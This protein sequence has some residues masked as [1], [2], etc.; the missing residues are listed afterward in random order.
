MVQKIEAGAAAGSNSNFSRTQS[1]EIIKN[2]LFI[3]PVSRV[4]HRILT[5]E[6]FPNC[7]DIKQIQQA[8]KNKSFV[9]L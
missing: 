5:L 8:V 1:E 9:S 7:L 3:I 2:L 6:T 4:Y